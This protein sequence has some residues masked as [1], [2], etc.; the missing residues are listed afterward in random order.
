[1]TPPFA[2]AGPMCV[3]LIPLRDQSKVILKTC[4]TAEI[5]PGVGFSNTIKLPD[6]PR[7]AFRAKHRVGA[8]F[9]AFRWNEKVP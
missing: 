6:V 9:R 2:V 4:N 8:G 1:M 3:D 7:V 5:L